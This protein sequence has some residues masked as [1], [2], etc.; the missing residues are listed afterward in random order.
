MARGGVRFHRLPG[1]H[2]EII[3]PHNTP[4]LAKAVTSA[5]QRA[6]EQAQGPASQGNSQENRQS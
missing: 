6:S 2:A 1:D 3:A 4:A 5:I